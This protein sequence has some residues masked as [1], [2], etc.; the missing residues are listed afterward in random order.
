[1]FNYFT[2]GGYL[3]YRLWPE[4]RVFIDS[5]SDFYGEAFVRQYAQVM[6]LAEG[7]EDVLDQYN[8]TWA[9]LPSE[10]LTAAEFQRQLGWSVLFQDDT[11]VILGRE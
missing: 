3:Q 2:W 1:M 9:V 6:Q 7:W 5:N 4:K 10:S 8:V 11:A